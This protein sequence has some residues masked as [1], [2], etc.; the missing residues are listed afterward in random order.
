MIVYFYMEEEELQTQLDEI[1]DKIDEAQDTVDILHHQI[2]ETQI[3]VNHA[4]G[5]IKQLKRTNEKKLL[6]GVKSTGSTAVSDKTVINTEHADY[7]NTI[8]DRIYSIELQCEQT[9][10]SNNNL[11]DEVNSIL[12][13][14]ESINQQLRNAQYK[15]H[16]A[17]QNKKE[18]KLKIQLYQNEIQTLKNEIKSCSYNLRL[19][20]NAIAGMISREAINEEK[21]SNSISIQ[22][23]ITSRKNQCILQEMTSMDLSD[24]HEQDGAKYDEEIEQ[25]VNQI[26][27]IHTT[28]NWS[29]EAKRLN[30]EISQ[31]NQ[32]IKEISKRNKESNI[33]YDNQIKKY[34]QLQKLCKKWNNQKLASFREEDLNNSTDD[35]LSKC[36]SLLAKNQQ[37]SRDFKREFN[38]IITSN[39]I[40]QSTLN[41]KH[42]EFRRSVDHFHIE[43]TQLK[44]EI[45][46]IRTAAS[47]NEEMIVSQ[48]RDLNLKLAQKNVPK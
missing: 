31:L 30:Q 11:E 7:L 8:E 37:R 26:E 33:K 15:I 17:I 2:M 4:N 34:R 6:E 14:N 43:E 23:D 45:E 40:M 10:N 46:R 35:L 3:E 1:L 38:S 12:R 19:T 29:D 25:I 41:K 27:E 39:A 18:G 9:E 44:N 47:N 13:E 36:T 5:E 42:N 22:K 16:R 24:M 20:E 48:I 21:I 28:I 32:E